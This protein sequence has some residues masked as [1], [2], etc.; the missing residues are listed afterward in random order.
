MSEGTTNESLPEFAAREAETA[1]AEGATQTQD[2]PAEDPPIQ[3]TPDDLSKLREVTGLSH[4]TV[5]GFA[6][7]FEAAKN[8]AE[9]WRLLQ[10]KVE[11]REK[12]FAAWLENKQPEPVEQ[13]RE[14]TSNAPMKVADVDQFKMMRSHLLDE[15]GNPKPGADK[16]QLA[17]LDAL[18][19]KMVESQL[20]MANNPTEFIKEHFSGELEDL[21]KSIV[22]EIRGGIE[23]THLA[24]SQDAGR[25]KI[26]QQYAD[27]L[28]EGGDTNKPTQFAKDVKALVDRM[29]DSGRGLN[30]HDPNNYKLAF[31][32]V[33]KQNPPLKAQP[34]REAMQHGAKP[35]S[36][37]PSRKPLAQ[38]EID[39]INSFSSLGEF[40][41][42]SMKKP[43]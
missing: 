5:E 26:N 31:E 30:M 19:H 2:P 13:P 15:N 7:D 11:G 18:S 10:G 14:S 41:V 40:L 32:I 23:Q 28:F 29:H 8:D 9:Y 1:T 12:E 25:E 42:H 3:E 24:E 38:E 39:E 27:K 22:N 33:D 6:Q 37:A 36:V 43:S 35:P 34:T 17:A 16:D 4:D 20:Q 21:K